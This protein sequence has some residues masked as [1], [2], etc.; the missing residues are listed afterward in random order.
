MDVD[1]YLNIG[2]PEVNWR[3]LGAPATFQI[4]SN[5]GFYWGWV[6]KHVYV[7]IHVYVLLLG[8]AVSFL[9]AFLPYPTLLVGQATK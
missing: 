8:Q 9:M 4:F 7:Y 2:A 1:Q 6:K 3:S 5:V